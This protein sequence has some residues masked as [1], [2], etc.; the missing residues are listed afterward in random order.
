MTLKPSSGSKGQM[1]SACQAVTLHK[2]SRH[3]SC[4]SLCKW[5]LWDLAVHSLNSRTRWCCS[6]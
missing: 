6:L 5:S 1:Q 2:A 4:C 3:R